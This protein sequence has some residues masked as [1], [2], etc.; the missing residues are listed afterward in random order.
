MVLLRSLAISTLHFTVFAL[1][2]PQSRNSITSLRNTKDEAITFQL[3]N[4]H[5]IADTRL[6]K[7]IIRTKKAGSWF[8]REIWPGNDDHSQDVDAPCL[9]TVLTTNASIITGDIMSETLSD[10]SSLDDVFSDDFLQILV[11]NSVAASAK[12]DHSATSFLRSLNLKLLVFGNGIS[13]SNELASSSLVGNIS[14]SLPS[15]PYVAR[16]DRVLSLYP[17]YRLYEDTYRDFLY[18]T[19]FDDALANYISVDITEPAFRLPLIPVPSR[20]YSLRDTRPFAGY[21]VAIKDLFDMKGLLTT[22]GSRALQYIRTPANST[23]PAI[24]RIVDLGG[25]LVGKQKLAQFASGAD[26]WEWQDEHY[27]W[28]LRGDGWLT[29]SASSSRGGCS[30]AAYNWLDFAIGTDTGSSMRRP[31]AVSGTYGQRPS[32][33]MMILEGVIPLGGATDTA[34]VFSRDPKKWASF[35]RHWYTPDLHQNS[36]TTGL[37]ELVVPQASSSGFPKTLLY[38]EDYLPLNNSAAQPILDRFIEDLAG[39][40]GMEVHRF[41]F[42]ATVQNA[43][44][45][46]VA[47]LSS[48]NDDVLNIIDYHPQWEEIGQP[49]IEAWG[50]LFEGRFPPI[51]PAYRGPWSTWNTTSVSSLAEYERA[52]E[53]KR[54]SVEW[55]EENLQFSTPGLCSESLMLYDIGMGGLPFYREEKLNNNEDASFLAVTPDGTVTAGANLCPI[56]GCADFTVVIG[57]FPYFSRVTFHEEMVPVTINMVIK[58]GCDFILYEMIDRLAEAGILKEVRTGRTAFPTG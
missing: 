21:R 30:I 54:R 50:E 24:Q 12:L 28:N 47:D 4:V 57:Q 8:G 11:L 20:L 39:L 46:V 32:Q 48:R 25:V 9:V 44:D 29:C 14:S 31:A 2:L 13:A 40:F 36:T 45:P 3:G 7:A 41:N 6:S 56:Y 42:T 33:G 37:S 16:R 18:G 27:P 53:R 22:G 51:D 26:P 55:Y 10:Y 49:L 58:R 1:A 35:S 43:T 38:P 19:Y 34:G 52:V 5:Y 15:G 23:A 17:V